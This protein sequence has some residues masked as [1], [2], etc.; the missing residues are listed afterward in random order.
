MKQ[1]FQLYNC[2]LLIHKNNFSQNDQLRS[3]YFNEAESI[4]HALKLLVYFAALSQRSL[5]FKVHVD[6][7]SCSLRV[8]E[9]TIILLIFLCILYFYCLSLTFLILTWECYHKCKHDF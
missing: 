5:F 6:N 3:A 4:Y 2:V 9:V 1:Q 8:C 7:K